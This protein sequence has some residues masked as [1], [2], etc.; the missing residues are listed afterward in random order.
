MLEAIEGCS[1][2]VHKKIKA[3]VTNHF[4]R[5]QIIIFVVLFALIGGY[6]IIN[7]FAAVP[8]NG[9]ANMWMDA[10]GGTCAYSANTI[11]YSTGTACPDFNTACSKVPAGATVIVAVKGGTY[12]GSKTSLSNCKPTAKI[13]FQVVANENATTN[14]MTVTDTNNIE[15]DGFYINISGNSNGAGSFFVCTQNI[16]LSNV[17]IEGDHSQGTSYGDA[18]QVWPRDDEGKALCHNK[19]FKLD[20]AF[21]HDLHT[22]VAAEDNH[23]D[24]VQAASANGLTITN[25]RFVNCGTQSLQLND[26][27]WPCKYISGCASLTNVVMENNMIAMGGTVGG[28]TG[29]TARN[30]VFRY[31]PNFNAN[32]IKGNKVFTGNIFQFSWGSCYQVYDKGVSSSVI[33]KNN[34]ANFDCDNTN[35][36]SKTVTDLDSLFVNPSTSNSKTWDYHLKSGNNAA[37]GA[38][39]YNLAP[40]TDID[41]DPR[42]QSGNVDIGADQYKNQTSSVPADHVVPYDSASPWNQ[43]IASN[44]TKTA[45]SD[46]YVNYLGTIGK[47]LTSNPDDCTVNVY[48]V[49]NNTPKYD[50]P[51][52]DYNFNSYDAPNVLDDMGGVSA[53]DKTAHNVPIPTG[54]VADG[55]DG[56]ITLWNPS[57]G[58][59]W[60]FWLFKKTTSGTYQ[61]SN[62]FHTKTTAGFN[63]RFGDGK[64]GRGAGTTYFA[65][66]VRKWEIEQGRID[67][68]LAFAYTSPCCG[69]QSTLPE[70]LVYPAGKTDGAGNNTNSGPEGTRYQL[71]PAISDTTI[72]GWGCTNACFTIAK[73]L[74]KY[75]MYAIDNSGSSKIYLEEETTAQWSVN[76]TNNADIQQVASLR[77]DLPSTIPWTS[78]RVVDIPC[79][80]TRLTTCP[81]TTTPP[82]T[83]TKQPDINCDNAVNVT[84]L[85]ILLSNYGKTTA[86][87]ASST[88]SYPRADINNSGKVEIGDLSTLLTGYGK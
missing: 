8:A 82:P 45:D 24:C 63:G 67:H 59:E 2:A 31:A 40:S 37:I 80:N 52:V 84:D 39:P 32:F 68:A 62:G 43:P 15:I 74:Q 72:R 65:G 77:A 49:D 11:G 33:F 41:G 58:D 51:I 76:P 38:M 20:H 16:T 42:P 18:V 47:K 36:N 78:F 13:T 28:M 61:A 69:D 85:S 17:E 66:L 27:A 50:V 56:Q 4:S 1:V 83:C 44:A 81:T 22:Y 30:N 57:T 6:F 7:S 88:P 5:L 86:Q 54:A 10:D 73:A 29:F 9:S 71:D 35:T 14:T 12:T 55:C 48:L 79:N 46:K 64:A 3:K 21:I 19:N 70:K 26:D 75:G 23:T 53:S 25:S 60:G 87:L 34:I